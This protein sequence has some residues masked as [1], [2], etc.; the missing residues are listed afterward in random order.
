MIELAALLK[1]FGD[2]HRPLPAFLQLYNVFLSITRTRWYV[3]REHEWAA[4]EPR[5]QRF[6][7][8][9][10]AKEKANLSSRIVPEIEKEYDETH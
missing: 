2:S 6:C 9:G 5:F 4:E 8:D 3:S 1:N 7:I 10:P